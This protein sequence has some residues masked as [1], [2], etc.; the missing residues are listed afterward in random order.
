VVFAA[1]PLMLAATFC[2]VFPVLVWLGV[3]DP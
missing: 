1:K 2:V 3:L